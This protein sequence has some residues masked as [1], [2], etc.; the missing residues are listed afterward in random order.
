QLVVQHRRRGVRADAPHGA[1]PV[2]VAEGVADDR[3]P[4]SPPDHGSSSPDSSNAR[5][6]RWTATWWT[7]WTLGVLVQSTARTSSATSASGFGRGL[8]I[9]QHVTPRAR[10]VVTAFR[11]LA[12]R[13]D[14]DS[15]TSTSP[16]RPCAAT[17]R[18]KVCSKP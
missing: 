10:A 18:A 4:G 8:V 16:G 9:A 15:A 7:S 12:L 14:V 13:P 1:R 17:W 6:T 5:H 2:D 11:T 3:H